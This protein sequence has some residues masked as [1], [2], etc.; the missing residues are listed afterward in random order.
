DKLEKATIKTI[1]DG[2]MTGDLYAISSL[3]NK[4]KVNTEDF[5]KAID[6]RLKATL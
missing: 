6:E 4:K 3:E 1:E 2:V 5:L